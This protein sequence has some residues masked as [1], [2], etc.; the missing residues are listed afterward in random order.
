MCVFLNVFI[1]FVFRDSHRFLEGPPLHSP[2]SL[3]YFHFHGRD[4]RDW[5]E[6]SPASSLSLPDGQIPPPAGRGLSGCLLSSPGSRLSWALPP[7]IPFTAPAGTLR[8]SVTGSAAAPQG[9]VSTCSQGAPAGR[10]R[11]R[12]VNPPRG[13]GT[14]VDLPASHGPPSSPR[15]SLQG[16]RKRNPNWSSLGSWDTHLL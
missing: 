5:T 4:A 7:P 6:L 13:P 16:T 1:G 10:E 3:R 9:P 2:T 8:S 14:L 15:L 11:Q 12:G